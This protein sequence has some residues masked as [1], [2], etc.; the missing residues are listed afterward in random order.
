MVCLLGAYIFTLTDV[1][2]I[3]KVKKFGF[4]ISS[5]LGNH[6]FTQS[7]GKWDDSVEFDAVFFYESSMNILLIEKMAESKKP[8]WFVMPSGEAMEVTIDEIKITRSYFD[9]GGQP[10]KQEIHF[11]LEAY[12]D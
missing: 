12:H 5:R 11:R 3:E 4:A 7:V 2:S 1:E 6:Q 10:I 8:T 9:G